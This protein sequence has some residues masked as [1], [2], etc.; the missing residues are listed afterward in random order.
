MEMYFNLT[1][2]KNILSLKRHIRENRK[3]YNANKRIIKGTYSSKPTC[4]TSYK[5]M[6]KPICWF[7]N[8]GISKNTAQNSD[9]LPKFLCQK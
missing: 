1:T 9:T 6:L 5:V 4:K 3:E 7:N 8:N 2:D